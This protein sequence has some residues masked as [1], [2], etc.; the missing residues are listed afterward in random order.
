MQVEKCCSRDFRLFAALLLYNIALL[1]KI[2]VWMF[3]SERFTGQGVNTGLNDAK[4]VVL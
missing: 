2:S 1:R 3:V 4:A